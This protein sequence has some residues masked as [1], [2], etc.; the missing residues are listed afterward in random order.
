MHENL[1]HFTDLAV[2]FSPFAFNISAL[3]R[4]NESAK[5]TNL[6]ARL[7]LCVCLFP[8]KKEKKTR[9]RGEKTEIILKSSMEIRWIIRRWKGEETKSIRGYKETE[10]LLEGE[11]LNLL[12]C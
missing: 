4:L 12:L 1:S 10:E 9:E 7:V 6:Y 3:C 5:N 8:S 11:L 2:L